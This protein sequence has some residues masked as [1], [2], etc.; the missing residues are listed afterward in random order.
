[1]SYIYGTRGTAAIGPLQLALRSELY[2][3]PYASIRWDAVRNSCAPIDLYAPHT[4]IMDAAF[5][6][7]RRYEWF[8]PRG[9]FKW[10]RGAGTAFALEYLEVR[11]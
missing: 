6:V 4:A 9:L 8:A 3:A 5:W 7:F 11:G 10:L 2:T 1:M